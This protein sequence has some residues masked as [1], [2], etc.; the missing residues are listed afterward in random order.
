MHVLKREVRRKIKEEKT[1]NTL[2][3]KVEEKEAGNDISDF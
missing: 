1:K 3:R 2:I